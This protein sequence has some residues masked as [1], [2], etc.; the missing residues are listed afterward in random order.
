MTINVTVPLIFPRRESMASTMQ[1]SRVK[2]MHFSQ[3]LFVDIVSK[4][5]FP[6]CSLKSFWFKTHVWLHVLL[7]LLVA[8]KALSVR[9]AS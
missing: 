7:K 2:L 5:F 3:Y 8:S 1:V 6:H 4:H 9:R